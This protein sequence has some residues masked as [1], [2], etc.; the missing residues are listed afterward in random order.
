MKTSN[1]EQKSLRLR[2]LYAIAPGIRFKLAFFTGVFISLVLLA[3]TFFNYVH[4]GKILE[5]GLVRETKNSLTLINSVLSDMENARGNI[6]LVE[7][8]RLRIEE[9]KQELKK[10]KSTI[11]RKDDSVANSFRSLGQKLGMKVNYGYHRAR[12]DSYYSVYF[13]EKQVDEI[14]NMVVSRLRTR[15]GSEIN[16]ADYKN[17]AGKARN[18]STIERTIESIQ[19]SVTDN[20]NKINELKKNGGANRS[21]F[22]KENKRNRTALYYLTKRR[23]YADRIF[24][25]HL[26]RYFEHEFD[27]MRSAG[28]NDENIRI[29]SADRTGNTVYDTGTHIRDERLRFGILLSNAAYLKDKGGFFLSVGNDSAKKNKSDFNYN[30]GSRSFHVQYFPVYRN[31]STFRRIEIIRTEIARNP[32]L[33]RTFIKN[34]IELCSAISDVIQKMKVRLNELREKKT[35]PSDDAQYRA[36]YRTYRSLL[37]RKK[38]NFAES[39]PYRSEAMLI[40]KYY[41]EEIRKANKE[42][43]TAEQSLANAVNPGTP[44]T[45]NDESSSKAESARIRIESLK[46]RI[47]TLD[48]DRAKSTEDIS[49]SEPLMVQDAFRNIREAALYD[50]VVLRVGNQPNVFNDYLE[51]SRARLV[52]S[53]RWDTIREWI[54]QGRSETDIPDNVPGMK[55]VKTIENGIP[56]Y[57]RSEA[58]EYMWK[59]DSTPLFA[60]T[61]FFSVKADSA[62]LLRDLLGESVTGYNTV[63]V[64]KTDGLRAITKN[65]K[66]ML[67]WSG[68]IVLIAVILTYFFAG[69]IVKRIHGIIRQTRLAAAGDLNTR[70]PEK[71]MDE[72]EE[73]A[74]SLNEMMKGLREKEELK[75]EISAAGEIQRQLLPEKIPQSLE[76][77]YSI[78]R[79]YRSMQGVGGDYYDFIELESQK[80]LFCIGDVSNHGV[81]PAMVMAMTRAHLHGIIRRGERDLINITRELNRQL[82]TET[83]PQIFVTFFIGIIDGETNEVEY[84]SAGHMQPIIYRYRTEKIEVL[85]GGGLPLGMDDDD[86]FKDTITTAK[87]Q[88]KPGD[89]FFQYTDGTNEAMNDSREIFGE[90]RLHK[91]II[92]FARKKPDVMIEHIAQSIQDFSG[93]NLFL[94]G[95]VTELNDD[96]AMI[97]LKRIR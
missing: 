90:E 91:G 78:G 85:G 75:G 61:G 38:K 65:R 44:D 87:V 58:E 83:P 19:L 80:I 32:S 56:S 25:N 7:D 74:V 46:E 14:E 89:V 88:L 57:S 49:L 16:M 72:I 77:K 33:W 2:I 18:L 30:T 82:Y 47:A 68:G 96:I 79:F 64:D 35:P 97:A 12:V 41:A 13:S 62:G 84:I 26:K 70:F 69:F 15:D 27:R 31:P 71:G 73:M 60:D 11:Y 66:I 29:V 48:N 20:E 1:T 86:F 53:K 55:N 22:E 92:D 45:G 63:I 54:F 8:M 95:G 51:S 9:K 59:L 4:E 43:R 81:G 50:L 10:Y 40:A 3:V 52:E 67:A 34:D 6:L 39:N 24:R 37:S 94:P 42:L 93:K 28:V 76:G 21:S 17:L 23:L 5:E 36:L